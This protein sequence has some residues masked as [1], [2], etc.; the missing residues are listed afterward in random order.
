MLKDSRRSLKKSKAAIKR[1]SRRFE[2]SILQEAKDVVSEYS[3]IIGKND[4]LGFVGSSIE[5]PTVFADGKT[6]VECYKAIQEALM[7]AAATMIECGSRPPQPASEKKRTAQ[8]NIRLTPQEKLLLSN[9]AT[10]LGFKGISDY[11][12]NAALKATYRT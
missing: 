10:T 3:V 11:I 1:L 12:R 4:N 6:P 5:L 8:V 9:A 2:P 7:V